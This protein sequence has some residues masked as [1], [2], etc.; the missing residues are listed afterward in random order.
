[1]DVFLFLFL[2]SSD[3][4]QVF[5]YLFC[6][7]TYFTLLKYFAG[8]SKFVTHVVSTH[9]YASKQW[10]VTAFIQ[11]DVERHFFEDQVS[12]L[13]FCQISVVS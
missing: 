5:A 2:H 9:K 7:R 12:N 11:N 1:M 6:K 3:L 10:L 8:L 13:R 4:E